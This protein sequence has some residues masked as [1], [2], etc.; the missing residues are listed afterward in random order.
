MNIDEFGSYLRSLREKKGL[1]LSKIAQ[2]SGVSHPYLSQIEN[3]K[4]K[5][6]PSPEILKKLAEPLGVSH[7]ELMV[8]AGHFTFADYL[9]EEDEEGYDKELHDAY[10]RKLIDN[11]RRLMEREI[12]KILI[13]REDLTYNG[14]ALTS[15]DRRRILDMLAVLFPERNK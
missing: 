8:E 14:H 13:H 15:D 4:V 3:G 12:T 1:T 7:A 10:S 11:D 5:G 2:L 9:A 6:V